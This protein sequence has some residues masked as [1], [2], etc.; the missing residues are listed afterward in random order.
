MTVLELWNGALGRTEKMVLEELE[1]ELRLFP[2]NEQVWTRARRLSRS[3]RE[4]GIT[5]PTAD[6]IIA[7][8]AGEYR[9]DLEHND[10]HLSTILSFAAKLR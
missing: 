8:C 2:V 9:L 6:I 10:A 4:K 7:A 3:C 5:T 1:R